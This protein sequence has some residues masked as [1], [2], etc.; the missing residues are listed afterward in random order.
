MSARRS[1]AWHNGDTHYAVED[2][3]NHWHEQ[4]KKLGNLE[5]VYRD[6]YERLAEDDSFYSNIMNAAKEAA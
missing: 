1:V 4:I 3:V 2:H 5:A 6:V